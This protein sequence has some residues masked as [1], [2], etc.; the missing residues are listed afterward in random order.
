MIELSRKGDFFFSREQLLLIILA[1]IQLTNVLDFVI[2]MP[3]G[4]QFMRHFEI[5]PQAFGLVVSCYTFSAAV[6]GFLGAF[7]LSTALTGVLPCLYFMPAL[8]SALSFVLLPQ[9]TNS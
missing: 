9:L 4:P 3:L 6:F 1:T 8:H 5:S 2:M 7:F